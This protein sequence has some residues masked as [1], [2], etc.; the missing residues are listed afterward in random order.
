MTKIELISGLSVYIPKREYELL[1]KMAK[2]KGR[3]FKRNKMSLRA[4]ALADSLVQHHV[5]DR[6]DDHYILRQFT[7]C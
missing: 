3:I 4:S 1:V 5:L 7:F 6:D 2:S